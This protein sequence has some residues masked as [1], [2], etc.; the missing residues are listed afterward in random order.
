MQKLHV[1]TAG[2][3]ARIPAG[4]ITRLRGIGSVPRYELVRLSREWR[5]RFDVQWTETAG[6]LIVQID[7]ERTGPA[8]QP[9]PAAE[10]AE[11]AER[12]SVDEVA[13]RL[14]PSSRDLA[15][16]VGLAGAPRRRGVAMGGAAGD[17]AS[18]WHRRGGSRR[19]PGP[20]AQPV[21]QVRTGANPG[22]RGARRYPAGARAD[23]GLAAARRRPA[24]P[25]R[26]RACRS[27]RTDPACRNLRPRRRGDRGTTG[28]GAVAPAAGCQQVARPVLVALAARRRKARRT[29]TS[30]SSTPSCWA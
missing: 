17:R 9:Q 8:H 25:P 4:R 3:L 12:L 24:R 20:A 16:V 10:P 2:D 18:H 28:L 26:V 19:E 27:I 30:C 15:R 22:T 29:P 21:A 14:V 6:P 5:Q 1:S 11:D 7:T 13:R 23:H